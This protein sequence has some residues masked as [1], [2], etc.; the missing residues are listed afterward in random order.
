MSVA[1]TDPLVQYNKGAGWTG[2]YT[3]PFKYIDTSHI[4]AKL[5]YDDAGVTADTTLIENTDYTISTPGDTGTLTVVSVWDADAVRLTIYRDVPRAQ[6]TDWRNGDRYDG[7]TLEQDLDLAAMRDQEIDTILATRAVRAPE[8]DDTPDMVLPAKADRASMYMAFDSDG[9]PIAALNA[10]GDVVVSAFGETLVDDADAATARATLGIV[11]SV[12][13]NTA[14]YAVGEIVSQS[15]RIFI[16]IQEA[17]NK[18]PTTETAYWNP[19][20]PPAYIKTLTDESYTITDTDG[21]DTIILSATAL[22]AERTITLPTAADNIRRRIKVLTLNAHGTYQ[23]VVDG[24][25][26]ETINGQLVWRLNGIY[27][28]VEL[29][30]TGTAWIVENA[31]GALRV[32]ESTSAVT[33][34]SPSANT[35]YNLGGSVALEPGIW[36]IS[37][38]VVHKIISGALDDYLVA[39][40]IS[41]ANNSQSAVLHTAYAYHYARAGSIAL[42]TTLTKRFRLTVASAGTYYLNLFYNG[43]AGSSLVA[44]GDAGGTVLLA[45]RVA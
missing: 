37:Y 15:G 24:E 5:S 39:A 3:I 8:T 35:W 20:I 21:F 26:A 11:G 44:Q 41:T 6:E 34:G 33:Q 42:Y 40:T 22:G 12:W 19:Y 4:V 23:L 1:D 38:S 32:V 2:P 29:V 36:D 17:L 13:V 9:N 43:T 31:L 30:C 28:R 27:Q 14:T 16:C 7:P 18:D 10:P 45:R 25:G